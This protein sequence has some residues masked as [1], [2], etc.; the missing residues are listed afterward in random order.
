VRRPWRSLDVSYI[1]SA[2]AHSSWMRP[3]EVIAVLHSAS[4]S[5][6]VLPRDGGARPE[7]PGGESQRR[8]AS[9][10]SG[11]S[12]EQGQLSSAHR[13]VRLLLFNLVLL[14][15]LGRVLAGLTLLLPGASTPLVGI[16]SALVRIPGQHRLDPSAGESTLGPRPR[17][18]D[19]EGFL[20]HRLTLETL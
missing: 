15:F 8:Q 13:C 17:A 19:F 4:G 9:G 10:Q 1:G 16:S 11:Q 6:D 2:S 7:E 18:A 14:D 20:T 5:V 12:D 3:S